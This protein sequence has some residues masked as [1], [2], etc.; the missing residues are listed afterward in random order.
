MMNKLFKPFLAGAVLS[1]ALTGVGAWAQEA[2]PA[3]A[4]PCGLK[5]EA[6]WVRATAAGQHG[7]GAFMR[8][9]AQQTCQLVA[10]QSPVAGVSQIHRMT[11]EEGVMK[12]REVEGGLPLPAGQTVELVPGGFHLMLMD[13]KQP[14]AAGA[15]VPITLTVQ[16]TQTST[17]GQIALDVPARAL[18]ADAGGMPH[19]K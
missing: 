5:V 13:L 10:V 2:K 1:A 4:D 8:L 16:N 7:T 15:S 12:M 17:R 9:T 3:P 14:V 11:M 18:G 6:P 19:G